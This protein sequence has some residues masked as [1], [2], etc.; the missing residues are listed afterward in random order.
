[1]GTPFLGEIKIMSFGYAPR[2]WAQCNGQL[3]PIN[4]NQAL[5]SLL[6]TMYGGNGQINFALPDL[7]GLT[8]LHVGGSFNVQGQ[9]GGEANHTLLLGEMP[10]HPHFL[11][12]STTTGDSA[13]ANNTVFASALNLYGPPSNLTNIAPDSVTNFGGSQPHQNM[14]P[15]LTLNFCIA[16]QGIFPS[17][18]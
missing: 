1:M 9:K 14:Q 16:L 17:R 10:Q 2:G 6:G 18:N 3:L 7:R 12:G 15:F 4:Q 11:Q 5:F 8:P 13:N